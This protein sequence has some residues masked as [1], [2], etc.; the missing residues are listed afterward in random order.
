MNVWLNRILFVG[1]AV[2]FAFL[3]VLAADKVEDSYQAGVAAEEAIVTSYRDKVDNMVAE[4][5]AIRLRVEA[6]EAV[7]HAPAK[8]K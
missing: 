8:R 7:A 5:T 3:V 1:A 6:L 4:V 2:G